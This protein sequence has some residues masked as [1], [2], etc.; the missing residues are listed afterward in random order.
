MGVKFKRKKSRNLLLILFSRLNKIPFAS[1]KFK[2][3]L[4]L[5]LEWI[6]NRLSSQLSF[7]Q[8]TVEN[9][10]FRK[11]S[12]KFILENINENDSVLDL[13]C[14][15]GAMSD[16]LADKA[17]HVTGVD[18]NESAILTAK[19]KYK[20]E[21]LEFVYDEALSYLAKNENKFNVLIL[22]HIL[23][24]LD[25]PVSFLE[26]FKKYFQK[27]YIELPDFDSTY[28]N[29]YRKDLNV[30]LIYT[31]IDHINEF[32]R[33]ELMQLINRC[34]LKIIR[35]EYIFGVQKIWCENE[36]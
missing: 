24:H 10:P 4:Y 16:Y 32:D 19:N 13:G 33:Y 9:H 12:K 25:D 31:D 21:N 8:Y 14:N 7:T 3:K 6:F 29:Q 30:D 22:S 26:S 18:Y 35:S 28:L 36:E 34:G 2:F 5:N 20:K 11:Y 23:E 1:R 17:R 27:I 15:Y